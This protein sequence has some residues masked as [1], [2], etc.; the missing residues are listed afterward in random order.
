[1]AAGLMRNAAGDSVEVHSAGTDPGT[2]LNPLSVTS[3]LEVGVDIR[4][5]HPSRSTPNC[6]DRSTW[7]SF[8]KGREA[9]IDSTNCLVVHRWETD[10]PS[11]RGID[12][13]RAHAV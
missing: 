6:C 8:S 5:E 4:E 1:M 9:T 7:L 10:E 2:T 12:K 11:L 3:L 13:H